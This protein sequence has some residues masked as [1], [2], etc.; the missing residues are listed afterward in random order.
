MT[1]MGIR[2]E[3]GTPTRGRVALFVDWDNLDIIARRDLG[4]RA[5]GRV[6]RKIAEEYGR[7][8]VAR[9]YA[10]WT[11]MPHVMETLFR[12]GIT[13]VY[14]ISRST[15]NAGASGT[16]KNSADVLLAVECCQLGVLDESVD[17]VVIASGD[18]ALVH[19]VGLGK[20]CGKRI[21]YVSLRQAASSLLTRLPDDL[22]FYESWLSGFVRVA[23]DSLRDE[24]RRRRDADIAKALDAVEQ[25]VKDLRGGDAGFAGENDAAALKTKLCEQIPGFREEDLGFPRFR[26]FLFWAEA[27]GKVLV[28]TRAEHPHVYA[29]SESETVE[30]KPLLGPTMWNA[31]VAA[32]SPSRGWLIRTDKLQQGLTSSPGAGPSVSDVLAA[33]RE[34]YFIVPDRRSGGDR[35]SP[36]DER[37]EVY[38]L[39]GRGHSR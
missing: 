1:A 13:P 11:R 18:F 23:R 7:V 3:S 30:G 21:V 16:I 27:E 26:H 34:S 35:L 9:A 6:L 33:A 38:R 25:C 28:D 37:A 29:T 36:Y 39:R 8:V 32:A 10:D 20:Q 4:I 2:E 24:E 15:Q 19:L 31:I 22:V 12:E 14:A 17:T 5:S